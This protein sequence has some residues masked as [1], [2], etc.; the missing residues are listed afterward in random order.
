MEKIFNNHLPKNKQTSGEDILYLNI[1][2]FRNDLN[3]FTNEYIY[4]KYGEYTTI[5]DNINYGSKY[6]EYGNNMTISYFGNINNMLSYIDKIKKD[7]E[8]LFQ[9]KEFDTNI[10]NGYNNLFYDFHKNNVKILFPSNDIG[11]YENTYYT[12]TISYMNNEYLVPN[13]INEL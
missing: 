4:D 9:P 5:Y 6:D 13:K 7:V 1:T 2:K 11:N 12:Q 8:I 3:H 10:I